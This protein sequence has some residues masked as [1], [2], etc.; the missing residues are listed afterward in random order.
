MLHDLPNLASAFIHLTPVSLSWTF[1]WFANDITTKYPGIFN[2]PD[3][4]KVMNES[5]WEIFA[6]AMAFY[7]IW[8]VPYTFGYMLFLGRFQGNPWNYYD[9][10]YINSI[11][12]SKA[13]AKAIGW[14]SS[15]PESRSRFL[16][17]LKFMIGHALVVT[18]V[19]AFSYLLWFSFWAHTMFAASL[20]VSCTFHGSMR[21][22]KMMT[23]YYEKGMSKI[24][25]V[26][27]VEYN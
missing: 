7:F 2:L 27:G 22:F 11:K 15:T 26:H 13:Q 23:T 18:L 20:F 10:V 17:V 12:G 3:P 9:N 1:R 19:V 8:W 24:M 16:P 14:D 5:L 4:D 21:Y 6:P 25:N